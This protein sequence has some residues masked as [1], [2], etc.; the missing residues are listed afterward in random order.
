MYPQ[1]HFLFPF[2]ISLILIK[3]GLLDWKLALLSGIIGVL[4]D[5]D[6]L[7]EH[8]LLATKNKFSLADT[9]NNAVHYHR[10]SERSVLHHWLGMLIIGLVLVVVSFLNWRISL[11]LAIAYYSH[12]ILDHIFIRVKPK[13]VLRLKEEGLFLQIPYY[14]LVF[15]A[16]LVVGIVLIGFF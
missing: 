15:D 6:H 7:I 13:Y 4:I 10:F 3:S 12:M 11:I 8:I 16:I 9:W 1:S 2:L 14:E 5:L